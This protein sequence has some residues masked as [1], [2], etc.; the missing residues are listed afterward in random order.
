MRKCFFYFALFLLGCSGNGDGGRDGTGFGSSPVAHVPEVSSFSL[1]PVT[2]TLMQADGSLVVT[3]EVGFRDAGLDIQTLWVQLPD[4]TSMQMSESFATETGTF[5]E[6]IVMPTDQVGAF[7]VE[8]W[9]VDEAGDSSAHYTAEFSVI[10]DAQVGSWTNRLSGL[11]YVLNDVIWDGDNF[12][13]VGDNGRILTSDDGEAWAERES[14]TEVHLNAVASHGSDIVAVGHDETVLLSTDHGESWRVKHSGDRV[15]LAAVVINSSQFVAGGMD[16]NTG[17]A[18]IMRSEDRGDTWTVV[19]SLPQPDHF[20]TDLI[21]HNGLFIATTDVF[22]WKSDARVLVSLDGIEWHSI[23]LRD[24]VAALLVILHDGNQF[25]AAGYED[26]VFV[27]AD[28][29]NWSELTTPVRQVSYLSAAWNGSELALAGGI[30]WWYW[31]VDAPPF[32]RPVGLSSVDGGNTWEIFNIDGYYQ[33]LGM[34]WGNGRFVSVGQSSPV[35]G[36]G[37]IYTSD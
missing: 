29:Y 2:A 26:A 18:I 13:A 14:F 8:I 25:I 34:A 28:G 23:I 31:W 17:D 6:T 1:S 15:R 21:Y 3:A 33:S 30:T 35:S 20:V 24:E 11:P 32:E 7:P 10:G 9:L 19:E 5:T 36:E 4:G 27:S 12:I 16:L 22:S 37:A